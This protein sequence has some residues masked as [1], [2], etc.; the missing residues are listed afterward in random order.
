MTVAVERPGLRVG[1]V[2][3]ILVVALALGGFAALAWRG[4]LLG[5]RNEWP[6]G[7]VATAFSQTTAASGYVWTREGRHVSREEITTFSGPDHCHWGSAT[8]LFI[9][10]PPG[11]VAPNASQARQYVRDPQGVMP[12]PYGALIERSLGLA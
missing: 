10:W 2:I 3:T 5:V 6:F 12:G 1:I 8:V 7:S 4:N 9:G 11:T